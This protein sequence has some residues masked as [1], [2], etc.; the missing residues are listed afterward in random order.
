MGTVAK[1]QPNKRLNLAWWSGTLAQFRNADDESI[2]RQLSL[3]LIEARFTSRAEHV[4]A[5]RQ[6]IPVMRRATSA[7]PQNWRVLFEFPMLRLARRIDVVL[8]GD[9]AIFVFEFKSS[10]FG[11][12][13]RRQAEDYALDLRDFHAGSRHHPIIPIVVAQSGYPNPTTWPL[14]WSPYDNPVLEALPEQLSHLL[15]DVTAQIEHRGI[16]VEE[17]EEAAYRPVPTIVEAAWMLYQKHGVDEIRTARADLTNLTRT[18]EAVLR[19]VK[20]AKTSNSFIIIF[21][22]GIPGAGKTLCGLDVVFSAET[23]AA[24][25]T[26]TLP[27]V[28]VLKEALAQDATDS[29]KSKRQAD[30]ETKGPIQSITNFLKQYRDNAEVPAE[31]VVVFDEAQ[32]AWDASY[33]ARKFG[34]AD[35][36]AGIVLDIMRRHQD[37]AVIVGLVGTGQEI[38]TGEA[39]L[40]EWGASLSKRPEWQVRAPPN[41][42]NSSSKRQCLYRIAPPSL[43]L[44]EALNLGVPIRQVRSTAAAPWV[45]A[46]LRGDATEAAAIAANA[47]GGV[48]F[49][50]VR[51]LTELREALRARSRGMRR[52]GLVCSS[53]AKRLVADGLWP[54]FDHVD[55]DTVANWF[56]KRWPD[57]RAS[58]ALEI[59]ATEFACQGLELDYVGLCWGG[60]W[61]WR[62][63]WTVRNFVGRKW[64]RPQRP[65]AIEFCRNKYRVLLTRA[66]YDTVIWVPEGEE[67][68]LTREPALFDETAEFLLRCGAQ[69]LVVRDPATDATEQVLF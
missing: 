45:D 11:L 35:S 18:T 2:V 51:S 54:R 30:R 12:A 3:R 25:L 37:F 24:F 36:E 40:E 7:M 62:G 1:G 63:G 64:Q 53:G 9:R 39:G 20:D 41:V 19:A 69:P 8:V 14:F 47:E 21:V 43:I 4:L 6:T 32:R 57:V 15:E 38:N 27:M 68:D 59:P 13:A 66:R 22:T 26:G 17:W 58:D 34:L 49:F 55:A 28:Y 50:L 16:A 10:A 29:R 23:Q 60:D 67:R 5:W 56:L 42:I 48:P 44:D 31:H 65:D 61:L 46:L 33:G 52:A